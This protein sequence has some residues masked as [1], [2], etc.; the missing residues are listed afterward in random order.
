MTAYRHDVSPTIVAKSAQAE[1]VRVLVVDDEPNIVEVSPW[2][3]AISGS[4]WRRPPWVVRHWE[5]PPP[6]AC[7]VLD[8]MLLDMEGL[9]VTQRLV[10]EHADIPVLFLSVHPGLSRCA[11]SRS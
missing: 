1:Q 6:R 4:R 2:R 7:D 11:S 10:S 3:C 5:D 8:M 9:E